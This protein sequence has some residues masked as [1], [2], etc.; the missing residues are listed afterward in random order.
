[1]CWGVT[2]LL[3]GLALL[4]L[5]GA[6]LLLALALLEQGLRHQDLVLG[7]DAPVGKVSVGPRE[8]VYWL[9]ERRIAAQCSAGTHAFSASTEIVFRRWHAQEHTKRQHLAKR[10]HTSAFAICRPHILTSHFWARAGLRPSVCAVWL[11]RGEHLF[12]RTDCAAILHPA[13]RE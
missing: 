11:H 2:N 8:Q 13:S 3:L 5:L 1:M 10:D 9:S 6:L 4:S 12:K 7:R